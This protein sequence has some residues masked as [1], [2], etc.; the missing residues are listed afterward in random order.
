M[1]YKKS[2]KEAF[3]VLKEKVFEELNW[4]SSM[5]DEYHK[6]MR[7]D[8]E[9]YDLRRELYNEFDQIFIDIAVYSD[10]Y[11]LP[12]WKDY[13]TLKKSIAFKIFLR[14]NEIDLPSEI[15]KQIKE[16]IKNNK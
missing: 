3:N 13:E 4:L 11:N 6:A 14:N 12:K 8:P 9:D 5:C 15:S 7:E 16:F 2:S 1:R 10:E